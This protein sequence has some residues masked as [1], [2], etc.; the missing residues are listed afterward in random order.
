MFV[1]FMLSSSF[2]NVA[3]NTL[4]TRVPRPDERASFSS[5][6]SAVQHMAAACGAFSASRILAETG[7]HNLVGMSTVAAISIAV[8]F[9]IPP[10]LFVIERRM[11]LRDV[12]DERALQ[13]APVSVVSASTGSGSSARPPHEAP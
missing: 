7:D 8:S 13:A 11:R 5:V 3:R 12:R 10:L 6:Q 1:L 9:S 2:R 4:T